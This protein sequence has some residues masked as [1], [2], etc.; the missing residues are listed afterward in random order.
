MKPTK[1]KLLEENFN[2]KVISDP[3]YYFD[4]KTQKYTLIDPLVYEKIM[5][6]SI[7]F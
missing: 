4:L 3:V 6:G 2:V 1:H 5:N 7:S